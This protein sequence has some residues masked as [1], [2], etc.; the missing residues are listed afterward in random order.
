M[1]NIEPLQQDPIDPLV[2]QICKNIKQ[3]ID[4]YKDKKPESAINKWLSSKDVSNHGLWKMVDDDIVIATK[5][6]NK[7]VNGN[8]VVLYKDGTVYIGNLA[9]TQRSGFGY[10]TF[11]DPSLIYAGEYA[12]DVKSGRGRLYSTK[13]NKWVFD[14][15]Y[16]ND[17]RNGQGHLHKLDGSI[18]VGKYINDKMNGEGIML[19]TNGSKYEGTFKDDLKHGNGKMTWSNGDVHQGTFENNNIH[20]KGVYTWKNG[21]NFSGDFAKGN[22]TGQGLM[23]YTSV[24]PI[25]GSGFNSE[26]IRTMQFNV[27][28]DDDDVHNYH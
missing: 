2:L 4:L 7:S 8:A 6:S 28:R 12:H 5:S 23:D 25:K 27:V 16:A 13:G 1:S 17:V 24:I 15:Q 14:G 26:S 22:I 11:K 9:N 21:E 3:E 10:R 20:G 19:W 18:Y